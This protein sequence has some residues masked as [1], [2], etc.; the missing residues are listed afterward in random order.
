LEWEI[1]N[2]RIVRVKDERVESF[3][4]LG[5]VKHI[6]RSNLLLEEDAISGF[7]NINFRDSF[8]YKGSY[9]DINSDEVHIRVIRSIFLM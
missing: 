5:S 7:R 6:A 4:N 1:G 8:E 2:Q 3:C 9:N